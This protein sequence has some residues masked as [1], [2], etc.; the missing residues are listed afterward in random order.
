MLKSLLVILAIILTSGIHSQVYIT[1][2]NLVDVEKMQIIPKQTIQVQ[3]GKVTKIETTSK[4]KV[5]A[6]AVF[7]D[8]TGNYLIPGLVDAHIHFFQSG[9]LY[10][11]PDVIDLQKYVALAKEN[12]WNH[13]HMEQQLRR[14]LA[15]GITTVVDVGSTINFLK[16]RDTFSTKNYAPSIFMT[17]PL[18]TTWLPE[19][20]KDLGDD[21]PFYLMQTEEDAR[22]YVQQQLP[23][24]PDLIKIWYI[25]FSQKAESEARKRLP[26]VKAVID[27]AHKNHLRVAVHAT[28][29]ITAQLAVENGCDYLVH[30]VDDEVVPPSFVQLLKKNRVVLCPTM[31]VAFNYTDVFAQHYH[32]TNTDYNYADPDALGSLFD[33]KHLQDTALVNRYKRFGY[34]L[35]HADKIKDSILKINLKKMSDAGVI[36]ATGTDAGNIGTLHAAS[37]FDELKRMQESGMNL[38]QLLRSSTI[39][40]AKAVG[41]ENEFGSIQPGKLANL[42]LLNAN[43]LE[44]LENWK[45]IK[46]IINKGEVMDPDNIIV[47]TPELLVQQQVN[48]YNGH[49]LEAF[50]APYADDVL[51]Y[52]FP[53]SLVIKGKAGLRKH[54]KMIENLPLLHCEIAERI[55]QDN[56]IIEREKVTTGEKETTESVTYQ[57]E[58]NKIK[59]VYHNKIRN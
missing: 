4:N 40:G 5:S 38:W 56:T 34:N 23:F 59:A 10:A 31:V 55:V 30:N 16:Q 46:L 22:K 32:F 21:S 47:S 8:G 51:F 49:N 43:P 53:D 57:I 9:G 26:L 6:G 17:G 3:N 48:G 18:L 29:R 35:A 36:I 24:H 14:Y 39:N 44:N 33:L 41:R 58:G 54:Y 45:K 7:I 28:E 25:V 37:Y 15:N 52:Q 1:N 11:R 2:T 27:E 42:V 20:Y 50:L 13:E 12:T 19:A